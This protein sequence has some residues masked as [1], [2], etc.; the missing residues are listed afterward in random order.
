MPETSNMV[1]VARVTALRVSTLH[2]RGVSF[3]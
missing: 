1:I 2:P 3:A